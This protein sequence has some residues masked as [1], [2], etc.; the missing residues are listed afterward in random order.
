[1]AKSDPSLA[2][3]PSTPTT[4]SRPADEGARAQA[5]QARLEAEEARAAAEEAR[6]E[7]E[8]AKADAEAAWKAVADKS[9]QETNNARA[10]AEKAREEAKQA[11]AAAGIKTQETV[12]PRSNPDREINY[13]GIW[14]AI[15][16]A[17]SPPL[18]EIGL[19][20]AIQ[21]RM[22]KKV[23][24]AYGVDFDDSRGRALVGAIIGAVVPARL[25]HGTLGMMLATMPM[26]GPIAG[27]IVM[28][29]LNYG[30]TKAVGEVFKR[31]FAKGGTLLTADPTRLRAQYQRL[32]SQAA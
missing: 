10:A 30:S 26:V 21:V 31:H 1:M 12:A 4:T 3:D 25:G 13:Y 2:I 32:R 7:L 29:G 23:A 11:R 16:S 22:L 28:P 24:E 19:V 14:A 27:L 17:A 9:R 6:D 5:D 15:A 8:S 18:I 20:A